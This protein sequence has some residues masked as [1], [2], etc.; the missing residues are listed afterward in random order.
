VCNGAVDLQLGND[1]REIARN[2]PEN[3]QLAGNA[4]A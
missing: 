1:M 3:A 2:L 4:A